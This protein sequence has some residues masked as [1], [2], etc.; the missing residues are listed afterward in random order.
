MKQKR[1]STPD[2]RAFIT[3]QHWMVRELGLRGDELLIYAIIYGFSQDGFSCYRGTTK[4]ICFWTGTTKE[5]VLKKLKSL[6]NKKMI[7]RRKVP[8]SSTHENRYYCD[9]WATITRYPDDVKE[10][11][12]HM[13]SKNSTCINPQQDDS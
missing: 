7:E 6:R 4:Y 11:V 2:S 13:W 12:I 10:K 5:T 9:Y 3:I 1:T 8:T